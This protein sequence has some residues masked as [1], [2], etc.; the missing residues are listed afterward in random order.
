MTVSR[1]GPGGIPEKEYRPQALE[2]IEQHHSG[3]YLR[4]VPIRL[5][6][7]VLDLPYKPLTVFLA[8]WF[9]VGLT[10]EQWVSIPAPTLADFRITPPVKTRALAE[11]QRAGLIRVRRTPGQPG[12]KLQVSLVETDRQTEP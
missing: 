3:L 9:R 10:G 11:L 7:T 8:I 6:S 1:L 2:K 12:R 5:I 4:P